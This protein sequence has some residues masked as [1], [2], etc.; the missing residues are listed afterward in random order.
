MEFNIE[1]DKVFGIVDFRLKG[2]CARIKVLGYI[3]AIK[4]CVILNESELKELFPPIGY[5]FEPGFFN[6]FNF[7]EGEL[8]IF[9]AKEIELSRPDGD[10]YRI[11]TDNNARPCLF[12]SR[13]FEITNFEEN[14]SF[15]NLSITKIIDENYSHGF[16][17]IFKNKLF[18]RLK[19]VNGKIA[20]ETGHFIK[21]W[22]TNQKNIFKYKNNQYL[23]H[24]HPDGQSKLID[25]MDE[26]AAFK[27]FKEKLGILNSDVVSYLNNKTNWSKVL[28]EILINQNEDETEVDKIRLRRIYF[29][30]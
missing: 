2:D 30:V 10:I 15:V 21:E 11:N 14:N 6:N 20:P 17:G 1:K 27:W 13:V 3:N 22:A 5:I 26:K 7:K 8:V 18:G 9:R 28:P 19:M 12:G 23:L 24:E 16:Y 29:F 25:T 4:S